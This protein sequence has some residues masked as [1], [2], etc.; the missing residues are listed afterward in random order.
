MSTI[1]ETFE[2]DYTYL[3]GS[4][5]EY[6]ALKKINLALEQGEFLGIFGPNGSG[7]STL[8]MHFNGLL[9]PTEGK[10]T[11]CGIEK[12]D[13]ENWNKLWKKAGMVF[14]YPEKQIFEATVF[15]EVA[16]GPKNLRLGQQEIR[17]RVEAALMQVGLDPSKCGTM[18]PLSLSGGMRRR[19]AIASVLA[20]RPQILI[21]DEPMAG[22]DPVGRQYILDV[23]HT[24]KQNEEDTTVMISHCLKDI[25]MLADKIAVLD[26]GE[27]VFFGKVDE[28]LTNKS[29]LE[30]YHFELPEYLKVINM[31]RDRGVIIN[32]NVHS[33]EETSAVI[34]G[35][36]L[37]VRNEEKPAG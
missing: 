5:Q 8:S 7:K 17:D 29:L 9:S 12:A 35:L 6:K 30:R 1:I 13:K 23:I 14:Q 27:L 32:A 26:E 22:L 4:K 11:V 36:L 10:I 37:E 34:A 24:R 25:L 18:Q 2:L 15:D 16:Y 33:V 3:L 28:L 31:L 19:V 20:L 21:L